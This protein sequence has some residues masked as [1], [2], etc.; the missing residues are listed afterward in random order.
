MWPF[1]AS[2]K[3]DR[4]GGL[5][6]EPQASQPEALIHCANSPARLLAKSLTDPETR[7]EW[8]RTYKAGAYG[9]AT[10]YTNAKRNME[11]SRWFAGGS[12]GGYSSG[13]S[14]PFTLSKAE[15]RVVGDALRAFD[16]RL[17]DEAEQAALARL[18]CDSDG[19]PKGRDAGSTAKPRQRGPKASSK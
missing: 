5:R 19:C 16:K 4:A 14:T 3:A 18:I 7:D 8:K 1:G 11:L 2:A 9:G 15:E 6:P 12:F 17:S 13:I 10:R